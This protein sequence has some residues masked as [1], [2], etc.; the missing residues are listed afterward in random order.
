ML[1]PRWLRRVVLAPAVLL[2]TVALITALPIAALV[3]AAISPRLPGRLRPLRLLWFTVVGLVVESAGIVACFVLWVAGGFGWQREARW[4]RDAH[5]WLMRWYVHAIVATAEWTFKLSVRLRGAV[6]RDRAVVD[7]VPLI[8]LSRHAGPG[9]SVLLV[10]ELLRRG[11]RPRLV[12]SAALRWAPCL[13]TVL[14]RVPARF[15][16][17][18]GAGGIE[19]VRSLASDLEPWDAVVI[20]PEGGNFTTARRRISI[21]R[22]EERG[23]HAQAERARE[24]RHVLVPRAG[25]ALAAMRAADEAH[26]V[27]VAHTGLEQLSGLVDLWRGLPMDAQV[28]AQAWRVPP[29][30]LPSDDAG[31]EDWLYDWWR[32]IDAWIVARRGTAAVPDEVARRV[33]EVPPAPEP[34]GGTETL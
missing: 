10:H 26:V 25:G 14:H 11:Y 23:D 20:F 9:D 29:A 31:R 13:D 22:L 1:P 8:V 15:V 17:G 16:G 5:Y 33:A 18:R 32:R 24:L 30:R 3:G 19:A 7:G 21:S 6:A 4:Y 34:V 27:L 12:L 2:T 28:E